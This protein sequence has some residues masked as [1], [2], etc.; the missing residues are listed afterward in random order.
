MTRLAAMSDGAPPELAASRARD[1]RGDTMTADI[2]WGEAQGRAMRR[3]FGQKAARVSALVCAVLVLPATAAFVWVWDQRGGAD[4]WVPS[5]AAIMVVL[6]SCAVVLHVM[7][8]PRPPLP[9][10]ENV[11]EPRAYS[12]GC[13]RCNG[14]SGGTHDT[15]RLGRC[16]P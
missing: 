4:P 13:G 5:V 14:L 9:A 12:H 10:P 1:R 3:N 8:R 2:R 11:G 16:R 7:S 6:A 15:R